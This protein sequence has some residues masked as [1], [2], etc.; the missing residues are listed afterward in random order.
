MKNFKDK[1]CERQM[2]LTTVSDI[3]DGTPGGG[4]FMGKERQ[5]VL[6]DGLRNLYAPIRDKVQRYFKENGISWWGGFKPT[7]HVLSS[8]M[9]CLNHL[10]A[11]RHEPEAILAILNGVR[12]EFTEV[13]PIPSE[14]DQGYIAF[15]VVSDNDYLNEGTPTRGSNCT[16]VDAFILARHKSGDTWLIPIEWKYTEHYDNQDKSTEDRPNEDKGTNDKGNERMS[17]YNNLIDSSKQL[18][19]LPEYQ[20]S[21]YYYEPFY[22]LMRQTLWAEQM[23]AHKDVE[24]I[25][26]DN[27]LHIHVIPSE[28]DELLHKRYKV[29][30]K[31]MEESWRE[32]LTDQ[33]KYVIIDP[34]K[35][36]NPIMESHSDLCQYLSTRYWN[37][38]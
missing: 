37:K 35:L 1:E 28:N 14:N 17:R 13:L 2:R 4:R 9:A 30:R 16:S 36:L 33:G 11:L 24:R 6:T 34:A 38:P 19:S 20:S 8:Q 12:P 18:K 5:F 27:Y 29:S 31:E 22:Q 7:G 32:M 25:K 23:I 15:E 10:F 3:F 21:L 26:A